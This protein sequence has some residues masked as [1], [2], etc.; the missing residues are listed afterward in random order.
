MINKVSTSIFLSILFLLLPFLTACAPQTDEDRIAWINKQIA[1]EGHLT[2]TH[3]YVDWP[4]EY[5]SGKEVAKPLK[6]KIPIE[7]LVPAVSFSAKTPIEYVAESLLVQDKKMISIY[8]QMLPNAKPYETLLPTKNLPPD[9]AKRKTDYS[10][11]SYAVSIH[12]KPSYSQGGF[13]GTLKGP[14]EA[15]VNGLVRYVETKCYDIEELK[16][17]SSTTDQKTPNV[18]L[19]RALDN[20]AYKAKDDHSAA[21]CF[22]D[23]AWQ[24]LVT[25]PKT[26]P[27]QAVFVTCSSTG[28]DAN[29]DL[30]DREVSIYVSKENTVYQYQERIARTAP[31]TKAY[32]EAKASNTAMA[33][34]A[35][36]QPLLNTV[37]TDLPKWREKVDPTRTLLNS[38]VIDELPKNLESSH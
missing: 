15:D 4:A 27:E 23:R 20:I 30:K 19:Q 26:P 6:L 31:Y 2:K 34:I 16:T 8:L 3:L 14:R 1:P 9:E 37:F 12:R 38:F 18:D 36:P 17:H 24:H 28:C 32:A 7:Y 10:N 22:E 11:S 35:I 25:S 21:N 29:F 13:S 33:Y 5:E